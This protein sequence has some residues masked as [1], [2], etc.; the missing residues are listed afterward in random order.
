MKT[1][2]PN[3]ALAQILWNELMDSVETLNQEDHEVVCDLMYLQNAILNDGFIELAEHSPT[4]EKLRGMP[5]CYVWITY[6][7]MAS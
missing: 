2:D 3:K 5:N 6:V 7:E 1:P 4:R